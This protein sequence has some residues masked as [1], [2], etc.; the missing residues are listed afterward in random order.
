ML[1]EYKRNCCILSEYFVDKNCR[2]LMDFRERNPGNNREYIDSNCKESIPTLTQ[3]SKSS[4]DE[5]H[6][7][8]HDELSGEYS[9][10]N[11]TV[12][13]CYM[14]SGKIIIGCS[15]GGHALKYPG[16]VGH[17]PI[18]GCSSWT[19]IEDDVCISCMSSG[20]GEELLL[21]RLCESVCLILKSTLNERAL[22]TFL[23]KHTHFEFGIL[24]CRMDS[25]KKV[26]DVVVAHSTPNFAYSYLVMNRE[27]TGKPFINISSKC[28]TSPL[29]LEIKSVNFA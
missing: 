15:T 16:R 2:Q 20:N 6:S 18:P 4:A 5:F 3:A 13:T 24:A 14:E 28:N 22:E 9:N 11:D 19:L 17:V 8:H 29:R 10:I 1:N 27:K 21:T 25:G 12:G 23:K 7:P 26:A